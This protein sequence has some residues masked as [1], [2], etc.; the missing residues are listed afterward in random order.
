VSCTRSKAAVRATRRIRGAIAQAVK[1][2][3]WLVESKQ[4]A[5][6]AGMN[7]TILSLKVESH[8]VVIRVNPYSSIENSDPFFNISAAG[9][10]KREKARQIREVYLR[11]STGG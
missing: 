2:S 4:L 9:S 1:M 6:L 3:R 11:V 7:G 5:N 10:Q 8:P